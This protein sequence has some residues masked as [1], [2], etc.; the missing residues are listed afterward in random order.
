MTGQVWRDRARFGDLRAVLDPADERGYKNYYI[1]LIHRAALDRHFAAKADDVVLDFGCGLG[2]LSRW[3]SKRARLVIGLD[4]V[5]EMLTVAHQQNREDN[6]YWVCYDGHGLPLGDESVDRIVS[7]GV[8]QHIL[9]QE[10]LQA[11]ISEFKRVMKPG[12]KIYVIE[13]VQYRRP[14]IIKDY[15]EQRLI[16]EYQRE[17]QAA[18][19]AHLHTVQVRAPS[20]LTSLAGTG[21]IPRAALGW[22]A[23]L[24]TKLLP[25]RRPGCTYADYLSIFEKVGR[26]CY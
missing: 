17:F 7:V 5:A 12:G 26:T 8:L 21:L 4:L 10:A 2:R 20:L 3:L 9:G 18:G 15:V 16:D 23:R 25:L 1:D 11:T 13:Q 19:Y 6:L 14:C 22:L 24:D